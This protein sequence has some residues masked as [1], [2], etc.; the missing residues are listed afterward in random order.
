[1]RAASLPLATM[2]SIDAFSSKPSRDWV[3]VG[4]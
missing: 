2:S 4:W 1:M 3:A